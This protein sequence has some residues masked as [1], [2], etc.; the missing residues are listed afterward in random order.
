MRK[1]LPQ[2][3]IERGQVIA[4]VRRKVPYDPETDS[5]DPN[6]PKAVDEFWD[7]A[8]KVVSHGGGYAAVRAAW[9]EKRKQRG[10][11][12][13]QK[14]PTKT[15]VTLRLSQEVVRFFKSKGSGWQTRIDDAL[16]AFMRTR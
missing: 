7:K 8:D 6:D 4:G 2:T 1:H 10:E 16:K 3:R 12:G 11:R 5:Y 15:R 14:A 13:P 9:A